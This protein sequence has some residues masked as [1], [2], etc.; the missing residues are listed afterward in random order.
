MPTVPKQT[1]CSM[2]GCKSPRA[3]FGGYCTE[4]GGTDAYPSKRY[5]IT[6]GRK[7][8]MAMYKTKHW[9]SMGRGQLSAHP[10]C[11]GCLSGG[12]I[13][14]AT[15]VDHVFPWQQIGDH[16]FFRNLFQSLCTKCHSS[17]TGMEK[18]GLYRRFGKPSIDYQ[19]DDYERVMREA[20]EEPNV[21]NDP[22]DGEKFF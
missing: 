19:K 17:K 4:H 8:A 14:S 21:P 13:A 5:N 22:D 6:T 2:L 7:E 16:A 1:K 11:A 10:L 20:M 12:L 3:K 15:Q 9:E 18:N